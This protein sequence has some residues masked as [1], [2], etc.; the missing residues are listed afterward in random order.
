M[1]LHDRLREL[2][3]KDG[4]SYLDGRSIYDGEVELNFY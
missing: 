1:K 2:A 3:D 4:V